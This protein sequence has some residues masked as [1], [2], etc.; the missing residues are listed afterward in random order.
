ME[1]HKRNLDWLVYAGDDSRLVSASYDETIK[2]W[3]VDRQKCL[4]TFQAENN[5]ITQAIPLDKGKRMMLGAA[6]GA[7]MIWDVKTGVCLDTLHAHSSYVESL[8]SS[9]KSHLL[10]S[11]SRDGTVKIWDMAQLST[12]GLGHIQDNDHTSA[13]EEH[14]GQVNAI[15]VSTDSKY[16]ASGGADGKIMVWDA[17]DGV[18]V[19]TIQGHAKP[20]CS[21]AF[22]ENGKQLATASEDFEAKVW[23]VEKGLCC[24]TLIHEKK[25]VN[26]V[27]FHPDGSLFTASSD[28]LIRLWDLE[29]ESFVDIQ[30]EEE[31]FLLVLSNDGKKLA[32]LGRNGRV[33]LW[34]VATGDP[35][36]IPEAFSVPGGDTPVYEFRTREHPAIRTMQA[37]FPIKS[38]AQNERWSTREPRKKKST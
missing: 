14:M 37:A 22:S 29:T 19:T 3:D 10:A 8:S 28:G 24:H 4:Q 33:R 13:S 9:P 30:C 26:A 21:I 5:R 23:D 1:G 25:E 20:I 34:D 17:H 7:L 15:A 35:V 38:L 11:G 18:L 27:I 2:L 16:A 12:Q 31:P 32:S 36:P 6:D